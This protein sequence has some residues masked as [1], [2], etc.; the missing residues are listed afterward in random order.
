MYKRLIIILIILLKNSN[1]IIHNI[2]MH[3]Q[4][5]DSNLPNWKTNLEMNIKIYKSIEEC[6]VSKIETCAEICPSCLG[7]KMC[8]CNY[9]CGTGFL[10]LNHE[11]IGTGNNCSVCSGIGE[12]KCKRCLGSGYIATWC[13]P[14]AKLV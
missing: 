8:I 1:S 13:A 3:S 7:E 14:H 6:D 5:S 4:I 9:C 10:T 12:K 2:K 11:I